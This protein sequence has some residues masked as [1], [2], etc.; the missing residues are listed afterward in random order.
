MCASS[1]FCIADRAG[2]K[3][4]KRE[5]DHIFGGSLKETSVT[6]LSSERR[7]NEMY[8]RVFF[9]PGIDTSLRTED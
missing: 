6:I 4:S 9:F 3:F 7:S 5:G 2:N 1:V 8:S